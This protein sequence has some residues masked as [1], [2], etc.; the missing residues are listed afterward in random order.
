MSGG[1]HLEKKKK[2]SSLLALHDRITDFELMENRMPCLQETLEQHNKV[3]YGNY[4]ILGGTHLCVDI[5][6]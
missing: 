5:H 3:L 2:P 6:L 4:S 1:T